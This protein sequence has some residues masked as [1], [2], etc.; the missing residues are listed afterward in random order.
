VAKAGRKNF[1][2][3]VTS[4]VPSG[5]TS[6]IAANLAN[7]FA[8]DEGKTSL[9]I[10]ANVRAPVLADIFQLE[11]EA[12]LVDYLEAD[13]LPLDKILYPTGVSRLRLIPVGTQ[14]ENSTEYFSSDR[15]NQF[16]NEIVER[17]PER[18]PIIDA[19]SVSESAD[20][21]ILIDKCDLVVLVIPYGL[22]SPQ[23]IKMAA[24]TIGQ[25]KL[26]GVVLNQ[27]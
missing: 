5:G 1:S 26:A 4:V 12:G 7:V 22:C 19:P 25:S 21:R 2:T 3:L 27:F 9:L 14:R 23:E 17:Y 24:R 20:T 10:D 6:L 8:F 15:M 18:Y 11:S 16:F 13:D